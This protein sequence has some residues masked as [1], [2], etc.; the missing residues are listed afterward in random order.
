MTFAMRCNFIFAVFSIFLLASCHGANRKIEEAFNLAGDNRAE[1]E[2]VIEYYADDPLKLSAAEFL[3]SNMPGH[4]SYLDTATVNRYYDEIDWALD[5][6]SGSPRK[7]IA[8]R[9][10]ILAKKYNMANQPIVE[11]V[12]IIKAEYLIR[13]IDEAF[14]QWQCGNWARHLTF[15]EFC[16]Y[17]LPSRRFAL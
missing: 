5:S 15:D 9:I 2:R 16:E 6:L 14:D 7:V 10:N 4:Y 13:N 17:L 11:D 12:K 1:L 3:I 8:D